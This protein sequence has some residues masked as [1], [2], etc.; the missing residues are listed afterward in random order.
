MPTFIDIIIH[1]EIRAWKTTCLQ[2]F[3]HRILI[4][5]LSSQLQI[6]P[7]H[8]PGPHNMQLYFVSTRD[9][10]MPSSSSLGFGC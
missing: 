8:I 4:H 3:L 10:N 5:I 7:I 2:L 1:A 6:W 9:L